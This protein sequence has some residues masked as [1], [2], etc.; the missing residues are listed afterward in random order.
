MK[1]VRPNCRWQFTAADAEFILGAMGK[2]ANDTAALASLFADTD[3]RDSILDLDAL[4][5]SIIEHNACLTISPRLYFYV[6]VRRVLRQAGIH[7]RT[8]ADYIAEVLSEFTQ[9]GRSQA[10]LD[11]G[12]RTFDYFFE[13]MQALRD[14]D[15]RRGFELRAHMGNLALYQAGLFHERIEHR[16]ARKGFPDLSYY[17]QIGEASFRMASQHRLANRLGLECVLSDLAGFFHR[18]RVA[19]NE[20]A[21]R[22]LAW[23]DIDAQIKRLLVSPA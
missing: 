4:H 1:V 18:I 23:G 15:E 2:D 6:V 10:S 7:D 21:E 9:T 16:A 13:M 12:N 17:E 8:V 11:G 19:L 22:I 20:L 14:C 5:R 3:S